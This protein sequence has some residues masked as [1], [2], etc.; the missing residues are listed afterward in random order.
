MST[1]RPCVTARPC[2]G[3]LALRLRSPGS[4]HTIW[5]VVLCQ[6]LAKPLIARSS[7]SEGLGLCQT[8]ILS[9]HRNTLL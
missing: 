7:L 5:A 1:R 2:P 8:H 6:L 9:W 4:E 3:S